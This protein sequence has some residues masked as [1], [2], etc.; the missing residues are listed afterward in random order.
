MKRYLLT[1][2]LVCFAFIAR[3]GNV[4]IFEQFDNSYLPTGWSVNGSQADYWQLMET[5][6]AGGTPYEVEF[7][8]NI[9]GTRR[10]TT[11]AVDLT[12]VESVDFS[13]KHFYDQSMGVNLTVGIATKSGNEWHSGWSQT[14]T[15]GG[16][17]QVNATIATEDMG[18]PNVSFCIYFTTPTI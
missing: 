10:L 13:F 7:Y 16:Q 15:S 14:Y 1:L 5:N 4:F 18:K 3:S 17:Y 12:G 6:H 11:N 2:A 9:N 8:C